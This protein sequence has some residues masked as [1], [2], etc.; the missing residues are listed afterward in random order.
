MVE[1]AI[2]A[3]AKTSLQLPFGIKKIDFKCP[4]GYKP[5]AKKEKNET[6]QKHQNRD[7]D[8]DKT[9]FHNPLPVNIN[10]P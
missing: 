10:Q 2:D 1:K 4:K 7:K 8:K 3:K 5:L 6:S 9:K